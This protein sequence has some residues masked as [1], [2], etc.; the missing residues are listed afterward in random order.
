MHI[1][2]FHYDAG[3]GWLKV[4]RADVKAVGLTEADFSAYSYADAQ[5]L[6]LEE[7]CDAGVFVQAFEAMK[8]M[9]HEF[10]EIDDGDDSFIRSKARLAG[11]AYA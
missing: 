11:G 1:F 5:H 7:D 3:H 4:T 6:Y 10:A 9:R 8:G 2:E